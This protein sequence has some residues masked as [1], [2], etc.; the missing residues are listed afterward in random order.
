[1][2][3]SNMYHSSQPVQNFIKQKDYFGILDSLRFF[4]FFC[5]FIS[6]LFVFF[7]FEFQ[8]IFLKKI[9]PYLFTQGNLGVTFFFVLSGFLIT[10]LLFKEKD[11]YGRVS[12]QKFYM[13]RV[14][15]IWPVYFTVVIAGFLVVPFVLHT[16]VYFGFPMQLAAS[17]FAGTEVTRLP[18]YL[19]FVAN[20]DM[21][22]N[23]AGAFFLAVLWS[24]SVEEQFYALWP[25]I[26]EK[27]S[28]KKVLTLFV[29]LGFFSF[30]YRY[31]HAY[32]LSKLRYMTFSV[33][34]DLVTGAFA[35]YLYLY[36]SLMKKT[37]A[38]LAAS[39]FS[40]LFVI[41]IP[42]AFFCNKWIEIQ[43]FATQTSYFRVWYALM[44]QVLA[45]FFSVIILYCCITP[46]ISTNGFFYK[47][48]YK[49][50]STVFEHLGKISYGL[51]CYHCFGILTVQVV[52]SFG[53]FS[54]YTNRFGLFFV[55]GVLAFLITVFLAEVSYFCVEKPILRF[56]KRFE[57]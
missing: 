4:A 40:F 34:S 31:L 30:I 14:L 2:Y 21:A 49:R 18:W 12:I 24:V 47:K 36:N 48:M 10:Y 29:L 51:Y 50:I 45:V 25:W 44:P 15:R 6:H 27:F 3:K 37:L 56:K 35:G 1:M 26:M 9:T 17:F 23:T 8:N 57:R 22:T 39:W 38:G 54:L 28:V 20:I 19:F 32:E 33:L 52:F 46:K 43:S 53:A 11:T 16:L 13:R 42:I 41:L 7:N 5:V 55:G